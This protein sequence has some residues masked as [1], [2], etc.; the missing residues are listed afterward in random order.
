M[1]RFGRCRVKV[2]GK[3]A[4][5]DH[6]DDFAC[7]FGDLQ[8]AVEV[9][10]ARLHEESEAMVLLVE[11]LEEDDLW[12]AI[13]LLH[14][15][16]IPRT[17]IADYNPTRAL[18]VWELGSIALGLLERREQRAI[19]LRNGLTEV[20]MAAFLLNEHLGRR[21]IAVN[22]AGV[23]EFDL[24]LEGDEVADVLNA[25]DIGEQIKPKLLAFAFLVAAIG[26][27][28]LE[29]QRCAI[30][31]GFVHCGIFYECKGSENL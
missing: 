31:L 8:L 24:P 18:G 9:G 12:L 13:G 15:I 4:V 28:G 2:L 17:E 5:V 10:I 30:L 22:E 16:D 21:D 29:L 20:D 6:A 23:A 11:V 25:E 7:F 26:P 14:V 19:G 3:E 27:V 1:E